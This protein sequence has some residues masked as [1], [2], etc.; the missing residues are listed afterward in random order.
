MLLNFLSIFDIILTQPL[1]ILIIL[2]RIAVAIGN[3]L[4]L[5]NIILTIILINT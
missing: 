2:L 1:F 4:G 3:T 5:L